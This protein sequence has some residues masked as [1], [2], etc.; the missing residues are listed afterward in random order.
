MTATKS[1]HL[2]LCVCHVPCQSLSAQLERCVIVVSTAHVIIA[3]ASRSAGEASKIMEN[4]EDFFDF[5][6]STQVQQHLATTTTGED[7]F[8]SVN[9][10]DNN[11]TSANYS[12]SCATADNP[13]PGIKVEPS[14]ED[15][16]IKMED[17]KDE[18]GPILDNGPGGQNA[19]ATFRSRCYTWPRHYLEGHWIKLKSCLI[20]FR[21][22][23]LPGASL[24]VSFGVGRRS[25]SK[26]FGFRGVLWGFLGFLMIPKGPLEFL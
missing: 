13:H 2:W 20:T 18:L 23:A 26:F 5:V 8:S 9:S 17:E 1:A 4:S 7:I 12:N 25:I 3:F 24:R 16:T 11:E 22:L 10:A 19:A 14:D 6:P 15:F 21:C